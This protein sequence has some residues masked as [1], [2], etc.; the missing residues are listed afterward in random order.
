MKKALNIGCGPVILH[1][2]QFCTWENSDFADTESSQAWQID[3]KRDFTKPL[4]DIED[5]SI[6]FILAWHIIEHVGLHEKDAILNEWK[7]VLRPGGK[8]FIACPDI[9]EIAK[10]IVAGTP[11]WNDPF[12]QAVNIYGPY[13]GYVGDYHKW[14]YS[15]TELSRVLK[16]VIGFG[17]VKP[18]HPDTLAKN[19]GDANARL[20]GFA[21]YNIQLEATK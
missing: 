17:E 18:L 10:K 19:I 15:S 16:D 20:V 13:N 11:P 8:L 3:K 14:G 9:Y 7:R 6:D 1:S 4:E 21:E 12:I 2:D 5:N